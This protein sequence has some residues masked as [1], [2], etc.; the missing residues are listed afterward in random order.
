MEI[1]LHIGALL[2]DENTLV[3][4]LLRN[5]ELLAEQGIA[6][7]SPGDYR[8]QLLVLSQE[9][10]GKPTSAET[11]E[12]LLDG[13]IEADDVRRVVFSFE[14]LMAPAKW[15][16]DKGAFYPEAGARVAA[17]R[18]L[19]PTA[20]VKVFLAIRNPT[21]FLPALAQ[22]NNAGGPETALKGIDPATIYWSQVVAQIRE[23]APD[24]PITV[25]CDEDAPL[26]WPEVLRAVAD[27]APDTDL[28]GW[29][30]RYWDMMTPNA[31]EVMR[32]YFVR[33]PIRDDQQRRR[34]L[35]AILSKFAKSDSFEVEADF[36]GWTA[37]YAEALTEK[38]EQ[39][40]DLIAS[41]PGVTLLE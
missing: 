25:W 36:L 30:A 39:D 16:I 14:N 22:N 29:F 26:I 7:P 4:C 10:L 15:V 32:R 3:R 17:V 11:Q 31:H 34:A 41:I 28:A 2:T 38:Y 21:T 27:H 23:A 20:E 5:R 33:N 37:D 19:F 1:A 6:V 12:T 8:P 35:S 9:M 13:L 24:V 18:R 40:V